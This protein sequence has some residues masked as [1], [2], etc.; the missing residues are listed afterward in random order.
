MYV[1]PRL[2]Q[3]CRK[4]IHFEALLN[5]MMHLPRKLSKFTSFFN[6]YLV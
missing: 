1:G 3:A 2:L 5:P 4:Y 6:T